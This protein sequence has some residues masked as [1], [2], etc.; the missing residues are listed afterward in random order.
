[1]GRHLLALLIYDGTVHQTGSIGE[2]GRLN[3]F[4]IFFE[5]KMTKFSDKSNNKE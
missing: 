4:G 1:M 5:I 2:L 3:G